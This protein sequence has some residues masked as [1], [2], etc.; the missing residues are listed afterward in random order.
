MRAMCQTIMY[1]YQIDC[2]K[3]N[4]TLL[5]LYDSIFD[6]IIYKNRPE[7]GKIQF[8]FCLTIKLLY[9]LLSTY[10]QSQPFQSHSA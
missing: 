1:Q 8:K 4:E 5:C 9:L 2:M 10:L 3:W 7:N 6:A